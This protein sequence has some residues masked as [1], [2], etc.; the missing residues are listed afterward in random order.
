MPMA[1]GIT[2][3]EPT[4]LSG[5]IGKAPVVMSLSNDNG[6]L[7]GWYI[8]LR[9]RKGIRLEGT[10]KAGG[11][12]SLDEFPMDAPRQRKTGVFTGTVV[13]GHWTGT[14]R[15]P[16]GGGEAVVDLS[17]NHSTLAGANIHLK[18][19][20]ARSD[21]RFGYS[22]TYSLVLAMD[23]GAMRTFS[24][25]QQS[26]SK[27]GEVHGCS[28]GLPDLKPARSDAGFLL[29]TDD[30]AEDKTRRCTI[31]L[32]EVGN[33]L[34]VQVGDMTT[35]HNDCHGGDEVMYCSPSQSW[36]DMVVDQKAST[37]EPVE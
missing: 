17:E 7:T 33:Y 34:Y 22:Y 35:E 1:S 13:Q 20:A 15:K 24:L 2:L 28:I 16:E 30:L 14:W 26:T 4:L 31:R 25:D 10:L 21:K 18:C 29:Q 19:A 37:C 6:Q 8:Y 12:Y 5:S 3:A 27:S 32:F 36:A 23:K 9:V 11:T